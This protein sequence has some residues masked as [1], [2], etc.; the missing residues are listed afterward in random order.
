[1]SVADTQEEIRLRPQL[2][3]RHTI[4]FGRDGSVAMQLDCNRGTGD[5]S[6]SG[7]SSGDRGCMGVLITIPGTS[8]SVIITASQRQDRVI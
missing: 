7:S 8:F 5:W 6:T 1:M 2:S 3:S 4:D